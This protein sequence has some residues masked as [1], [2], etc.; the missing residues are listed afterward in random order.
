[1]KGELDVNF[2]EGMGCVGGCVGGPKVVV[3]KEIGRENVNRYG[4]EAQFKT[5]LDSPCVMKVLRM[6]GIDS[7]KELKEDNEKSGIFLRDLHN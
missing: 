2:L 6:I 4:D 5:P 3:D 1:M 7:I